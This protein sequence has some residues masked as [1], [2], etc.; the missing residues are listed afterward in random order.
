ME[1]ALFADD[2]CF[3]FAHS[4]I[5]Q[6]NRKIQECIDAVVKWSAEKKMAIKVKTREIT[7]SSTDTKEAKWKP[8][9]KA[10]CKNVPFNPTPK[11]LG[12]HFDSTLS[13]AKHVK[14]LTEKAENR[15]R[16]LASLTSTKWG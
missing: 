8:N 15:K 14:V 12:V 7:F 6:A 13:F 1:A 10:F 16:M 5:N 2:I 9:V 11:F 4:D 3:R